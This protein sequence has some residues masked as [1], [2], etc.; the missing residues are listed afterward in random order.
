MVAGCAIGGGHILHM[1]CDLTI[2]VDNAIFGQT[3]PKVGSFGAVYGSSIMSRLIGPKKAREMSFLTRFYTASEAEKMGLVNTV[4]PLE[5]LEKETVK[6]QLS[7]PVDDG[8]AGLQ[9]LGGNA[10]FLYYGTEEGNEGR[11]A[12]M[13]RRRP[14]FSKFLPR[15]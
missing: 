7:M 15:P 13:Q 2:A 3:G 8:H 4:V 1:V 9:E 6:C 5:N 12:Y 14:D 11:T 10:T